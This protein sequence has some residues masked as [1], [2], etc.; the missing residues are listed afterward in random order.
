MRL[1]EFAAQIVRVGFSHRLRVE[2][3]ARATCI[4]AENALAYP[5]AET[6]HLVM[7]NLSTHSRKA[8]TDL[9]G[10]GRGGEIRSCFTA[11]YTRRLA[12]G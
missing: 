3:F 11:H 7:D 4:I 2:A 1:D 10:E 8:L 5:Q 9:Y 6:I 12:V